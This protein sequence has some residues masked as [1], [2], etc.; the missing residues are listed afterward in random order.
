MYQFHKEGG[1]L[2]GVGG[3][4]LKKPFLLGGGGGGI[5]WNHTLQRLVV[6]V[7]VDV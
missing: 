4:K 6:K 7:H 2:R 5:S 1:P 3:V